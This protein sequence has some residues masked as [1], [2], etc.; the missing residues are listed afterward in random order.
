MSMEDIARVHRR[1]TKFLQGDEGSQS[2]VL[3]G[4]DHLDSIAMTLSLLKESK[5]GQTIGKLRKH[6]DA[7]VAEKAKHLV[8]KWKALA[9]SPRTSTTDVTKDAPKKTTEMAAVA[10]KLEG[11]VEKTAEKKPS[12]N[13]LPSNLSNVRTTVRKK[14]KEVLELADEDLRS[15]A[16]FAAMSIETAMAKLYKMDKGLEPADMKKE[17]TSKFR[18]LSFN[19][20]KNEM[21]RDEVLTLTVTADQLVLMTP[22]ELATQELRLE[23]DKFR[24]DAFQSSRLDWDVANADKINKQCGITDARGLFT[25]GKC[26][27]TNTSNTQKQTRSADEPMTVFVL[28]HDC[29]KRWKC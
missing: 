22:D 17:Y 1:L 21:L 28:C 15:E 16:E 7:K 20:K 8:K 12:A 3:D 5:I 23:K 14:L 2:A 25:C 24:D 10:K 19:L 6:D 27:S 4:L 9:L 18:Q 13:F 26:K 29:G 11:K